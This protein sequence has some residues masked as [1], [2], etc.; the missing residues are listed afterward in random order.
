MGFNI[1]TL[2]DND[3]QPDNGDE[4][5]AID[6]CDD[7]EEDEGSD[8]RKLGRLSYQSVEANCEEMPI[9]AK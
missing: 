1:N 9:C 6:L 8:Q 5:C 7:V 3:D 4:N 2:L